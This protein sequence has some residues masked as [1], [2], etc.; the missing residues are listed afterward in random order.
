MNIIINKKKKSSLYSVKS[1]QALQNVDIKSLINSEKAF[2][3]LKR[4]S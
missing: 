4:N 3:Y 2:Y 1:A